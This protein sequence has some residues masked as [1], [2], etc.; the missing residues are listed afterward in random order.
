MTEIGIALSLEERSAP[1]VVSAAAKAEEAV[2]VMRRLW[3]GETVSHEGRHY[4]VE[5]ARIY[6]LPEEPPPVLVSGFHEGS[7]EL[8]ARIGDGFVTTKPDA[9]AIVTYRNAGGSG[10]TQTSLKCC[11]GPD[12]EACVEIAHRL[13]PNA[14][15]AG[16]LAQVL[17]TPAHFEQA[18]ELVSKEAIAS[19]FAC[20]PRSPRLRAAAATSSSRRRRPSSARARRARRS[21]SSASSRAIART[22]KAVRS[23]VPPD[24]SS[25]R[26][27]RRPASRGTTCT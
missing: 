15:L 17:P 3:T 5:H 20:G 2:E 26:R 6:S 25:R 10:P 9:E 7:I 18:S 14:A 21:C 4:R 16:E 24:R 22:G 19:T 8:A 13:W 23:S 27:S 1:E 11:Y 12:G